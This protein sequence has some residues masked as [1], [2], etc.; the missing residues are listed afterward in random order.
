MQQ[1]LELKKIWKAW[2]KM[3]S[4]YIFLK[5]FQVLFDTEIWCKYDKFDIAVIAT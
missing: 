5:K 1:H 2:N 3:E 4:F